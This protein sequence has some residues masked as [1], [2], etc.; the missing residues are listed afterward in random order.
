LASVIDKAAGR[1]ALAGRGNQLWAY[2]D[3]P[4]QYDAWDI[5]ETYEQEGEEVAGISGLEIVERGPLRAAVRV[6]RTFRGSRIQQTYRL[7]TG[8][9]RLDVVTEIDW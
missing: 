5:E 6:S 8:S 7:V 1:E 9:R 3:K 4:R 2:T